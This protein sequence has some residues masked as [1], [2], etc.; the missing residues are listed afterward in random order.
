MQVKILFDLPTG[1][2]KIGDTPH[3]RI[4]VARNL[5]DLGYAEYYTPPLPPLEMHY[6]VD[7]SDYGLVILRASCN[8]CPSTPHGR[9][10]FTGEPD[11]LLD[12]NHFNVQH[13]CGEQPSI[14]PREWIECYRAARAGRVYK[15]A[16]GALGLAQA[17]YLSNR[18]AKQIDRYERDRRDRASGIGYEGRIQS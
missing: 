8:R 12:T 16:E 5:V 17:E 7:V 1:K 13:Q 6:S 14:V 15:P 9:W 10:R 2:Y 3:L 11:L 4:E 18:E